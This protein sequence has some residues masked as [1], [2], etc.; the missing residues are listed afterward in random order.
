MNL[1]VKQLL[2]NHTRGIPSNVK[3]YDAQYFEEQ[4]IPNFIDKTEL[5]QYKT[6]LHSRKNN[7]DHQIR[8]EREQK[9]LTDQIKNKNSEIEDNETKN[10]QKEKENFNSRSDE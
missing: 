5:E 7:L 6:D 4:E 1:T 3:H 8:A 2:L 10:T 9:V